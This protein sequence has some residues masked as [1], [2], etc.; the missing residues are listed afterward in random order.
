[1]LNAWYARCKQQQQQRLTMPLLLTALPDDTLALVARH[2]VCNGEAYWFAATCQAARIAVRTACTQL[3]IAQPTSRL[4]TVFTSLP[5]LRAGLRINRVKIP[6]LADPMIRGAETLPQSMDGHYVWTPSACRAIVAGASIDVLDYAW[7]QWRQSTKAHSVHPMSALP[8]I[9]RLNRP[10]L[11][12]ETYSAGLEVR[13]VS[14]LDSL[15]RIFRLSIDGHPESIKLFVQAILA[16]LAAGC[17]EH[18]A[19]WV[20]TKLEEVSEPIEAYAWRSWLSSG[21]VRGGSQDLVHAA[22]RGPTP[23]AALCMITG[24]MMPRFASRAPSERADAIVDVTH[25]V[26][27]KLC[28]GE[29]GRRAAKDNVWK[30]LKEAWP[31][32]LAHLLRQLHAE[33][34]GVAGVSVSTLHRNALRV[35]DLDAYEWIQQEMDSERGWMHQAVMCHPGSVTWTTSKELTT[36]RHALLAQPCPRYAF[37]IHVLSFHLS[38][39]CSVDTQGGEL[40]MQWA[41][42]RG[43]V[44]HSYADV[45]LYGVSVLPMEETKQLLELSI[46]ACCEA[47]QAFSRR[48]GVEQQGAVF[49]ALMPL[50]LD[51]VVRGQISG[52]DPPQVEEDGEEQRSAV[53]EYI[54]SLRHT[55]SKDVLF[56][57]NGGG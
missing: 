25:Q 43:A 18:A 12:E 22:L 27:L 49:G 44:V 26:L 33:S 32:G 14:P 2:I 23:Y 8:L 38:S 3:E 37:A 16:P 46:T 19:E 56:H 45:L 10:D 28:Q 31:M 20:Y 15:H 29:L 6:T 50:L 54:S 48:A 7:P 21:A 41:R 53:W 51:R 30:W 39:M 57:S 36:M 34:A 17:A 5:R 1:M 52:V 40:R 13:T 9:C 47:L 11:L 24:W 35:C 42:S 55:Y 4:R